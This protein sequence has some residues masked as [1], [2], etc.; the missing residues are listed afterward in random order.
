[1]ESAYLHHMRQNAGVLTPAKYFL[2]SSDKICYISPVTK[3]RGHNGRRTAL[4][5]AGTHED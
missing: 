3:N 2:V 1:M 5:T 4:R